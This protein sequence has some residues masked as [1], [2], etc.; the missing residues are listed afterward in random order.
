M[1]LR[2]KDTGF[3]SCSLYS[4]PLRLPFFESKE[5]LLSTIEKSDSNGL[6]PWYSGPLN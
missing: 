4:A 2:K 3:F 6:P 1:E 5:G